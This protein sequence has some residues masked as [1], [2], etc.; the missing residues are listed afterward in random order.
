MIDLMFFF[1]SSRRRHTRCAL[2]T[3]VQ[4]C[5]LPILTYATPLAPNGQICRTEPLREAHIPAKALAM[6]KPVPKDWITGISPYVPGKAASDD[7]RK[8]AKLSANENPLGTSPKAREAFMAATA[9]LATYP[10]PAAA[11]LREGIAAQYGLD[12]ARVIYGTGSDE[13]LH[14]AASAYAGP[15]DEVLYVRYGFSV[16]DKIGRAH[17]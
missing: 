12:P 2:V 4:T 10:D 17:V 7:G 8:L 14:L 16:Y 1:F 3:G 5:A 11:A 9:D 15:G 13:L 6:T